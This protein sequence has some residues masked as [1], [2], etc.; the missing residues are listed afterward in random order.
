MHVTTEM[1]VTFTF[2]TRWYQP[3][4]II[5]KWFTNV[6][7]FVTPFSFILYD[8]ANYTRMCVYV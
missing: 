5:T 8:L 4:P 3:Y 6:P 1:E 2:I 7:F